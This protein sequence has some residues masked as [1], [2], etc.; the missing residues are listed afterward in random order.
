MAADQLHEQ[1]IEI[2]KGVGGVTCLLNR[3]KESALLLGNFVKM[4]LT[5]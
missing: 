4:E 5:T 2:T 1:N 3:E